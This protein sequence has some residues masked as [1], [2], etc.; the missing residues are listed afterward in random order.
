MTECLQTRKE[1]NKKGPRRLEKAPIKGLIRY[2]FRYT[3]KNAAMMEGSNLTNLLKF[4]K[5]VKI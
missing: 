5:L 3:C 1:W 2:L 4:H